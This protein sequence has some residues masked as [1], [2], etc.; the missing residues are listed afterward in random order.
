MYE[1]LRV[2]SAGERL[3][4]V[5]CMCNEYNYECEYIRECGQI[6]KRGNKS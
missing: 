5:V 1:D 2:M 4:V 6:G 3:N